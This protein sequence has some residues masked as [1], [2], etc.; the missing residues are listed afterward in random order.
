MFEPRGEDREMSE[1]QR[2]AVDEIAG[3]YNLL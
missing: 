3:F 1:E 2:A